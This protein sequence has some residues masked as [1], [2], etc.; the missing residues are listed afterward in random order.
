MREIRVGRGEGRGEWVGE[1]KE[2]EVIERLY[3]G[4]GLDRSMMIVHRIN[5]TFSINHSFFLFI[6]QFSHLYTD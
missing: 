4:L 1:K 5:I 6:Y 3:R 2:L